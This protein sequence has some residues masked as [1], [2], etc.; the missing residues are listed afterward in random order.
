MS[1]TTALPF[2][3]VVLRRRGCEPAAI[4]AAC[5]ISIAQAEAIPGGAKPIG[6]RA[7]GDKSTTVFDR[8]LVTLRRSHRDYTMAPVS[9]PIIP[10]VWPTEETDLNRVRPVQWRAQRKAS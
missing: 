7:Q 9:L 1:S 3:A 5:G 8:M 4:A 10:G 2:R 6:T